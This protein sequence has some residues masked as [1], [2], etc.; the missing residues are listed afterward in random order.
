[1][2]V[3]GRGP[4]GN[5]TS[6]DLLRTSCEHTLLVFFSPLLGSALDSLLHAPVVWE[7]FAVWITVRPP[8]EWIKAL[9]FWSG[10]CFTIYVDAGEI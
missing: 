2:E 1:M 9:L 5:R 4:N 8:V 10:L 6:N 3:N 7:R